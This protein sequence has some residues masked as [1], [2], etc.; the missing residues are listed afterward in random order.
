M[1]R[2]AIHHNHNNDDNHLVIGIGQKEGDEKNGMAASHVTVDEVGVEEEVVT[3]NEVKVEVAMTIVIEVGLHPEVP[4]IA[5]AHQVDIP[6][7]VVSIV[8]VAANHVIAIVIGVEVEV[9]HE[10]TK[11][12]LQLQIRTKMNVIPR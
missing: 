12:Q 3:A 6:R 7:E 1:I 10:K 5:T 11:N 9:D 2:V 8:A 4:D